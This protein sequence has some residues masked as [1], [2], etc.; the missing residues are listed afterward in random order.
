MWTVKF[1]FDGSEVFFGSLSKK[2]NVTLTGYPISNYEKNNTLYVN[3]VGT[4]KGELKNKKAIIGFMKNSKYVTKM[5]MKNDFMMLLIEEDSEFKPFYS[6][7]FIYASPV[8]IKNGTYY[9]HL[10][11]WYREDI[12]KLLK[13]IRKKYKTNLQLIKEGQLDNIS[14]VGLQPDLTEKQKKAYE[15]AVETGYYNY[16][17][18]IELKDLAKISKIS[19]STYQQHLRYAEKKLS[20]FFLGKQ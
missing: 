3:I 15:L 11:S 18:S 4:L 12:E 16:P 10:A 8:L 2:F 20:R 1:D 7:H 19:Y 14:L 17:K 5:E 6:P 9:Y 13:L